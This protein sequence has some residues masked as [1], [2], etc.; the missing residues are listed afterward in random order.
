MDKNYILLTGAGF[1]RNW[2]GW[3][4]DEIFE[5]LIGCK[6]IHSDGHLRYTLWECKDKGFEEA[7]GQIQLEYNNNYSEESRDRVK[8]FNKSLL[9]AF[10]A[11]NRNFVQNNSFCDANNKIRKIIEPI[12]PLLAKFNA[13]FTLNQDS[14][15]EQVYQPYRCPHLINPWEGLYIPGMKP[16]DEQNTPISSNFLWKS[17][18]D[19]GYRINTIIPTMNPIDNEEFA[20][21]DNKYQPYFKLHGSSNWKNREDENILIMGSNKSKLI[22]AHPILAWYSDQFSDYLSKPKTYL[23]I[24]GY[25]FKDT[26]INDIIIKSVKENKDLKL[27]IINTSGTDSIPNDIKDI[28][29]TTIV[30]ASRRPLTESVKSDAIEE[31]KIMKFFN[32]DY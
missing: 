13:I 11:M 30:G 14:L 27:Y 24:V 18:S 22:T 23:M 17:N 9:D 12:Q 31:A 10:D 29:S 8:N 28:L 20:L 3:L 16:I 6:E 32:T 4:G 25:S 26:H 2:G 19:G 15:L 5:Y 7:L 21:D 1:S